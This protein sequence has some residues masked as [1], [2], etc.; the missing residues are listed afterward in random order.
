MNR[1][2]FHLHEC[3]CERRRRRLDRAQEVCDLIVQLA[4]NVVEATCGT[5]GDD[6]DYRLRFWLSREIE[7]TADYSGAHL[8]LA[9]ELRRIAGELNFASDRL[10]SKGGVA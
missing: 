2:L 3:T 5:L 10:E 4:G 1:I 7:P 9:A 8:Y 6:P